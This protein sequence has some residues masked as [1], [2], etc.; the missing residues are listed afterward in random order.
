MKNKLTVFGTIQFVSTRF[1]NKAYSAR[2]IG[3]NGVVA[4]LAAS[5]YT[6]VDLIG[7]IGS[8]LRKTCLRELLGNKINTNHIEQI[9]GKTFDYKATYNSISY[10]LLDQVIGFGVYEKYFPRA[11]DEKINHSRY[12][13]FSGS[14]PQLSLAIEKQLLN[15]EIVAVD[16]LMY[17]LKNNFNASIELINS[18]MILFINNKEYEFLQDKLNSNPFKAFKRLQY[19]IRKKGKEGI[20][21]I[22]PDNIFSFIPSEIAKPLNPTN[23]GDVVSGAIMGMLAMGRSLN[24]HLKEII[25]IA[26]DEALKVILNDKFYRKE[27]KKDS[28]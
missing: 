18:A 24:T 8:D 2:Y 23:A 17:H 7:V 3:G 4:S 26:Q 12:I 21:V 11:L 5:K 22:T 14:K 10:D 19:I 20:D 1:D 25:N 16:T 27:Y 15:S 28:L 13:L 6:Q 9:S